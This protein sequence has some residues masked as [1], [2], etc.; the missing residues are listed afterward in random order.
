MLETF[1]SYGALEGLQVNVKVDLKC[2]LSYDMISVT[3][4]GVW[5]YCEVVQV[6]WV[7]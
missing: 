4:C 5:T 3:L 7:C 1:W 6:Q 2:S